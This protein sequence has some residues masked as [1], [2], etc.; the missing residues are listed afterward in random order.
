MEV[1]KRFWPLLFLSS[2]VSQP[3][4]PL[5]SDL[6]PTD[7]GL[8]SALLHCDI[9]NHPHGNKS[10]FLGN[11][12]TYYDSENINYGSNAWFG[13]GI[14]DK[15]ALPSW[16]S[17]EAFH[18]GNLGYPGYPGGD[19][20]AV[21]PGATPD[22]LRLAIIDIRKVDNVLHYHYFSNETAL[23][24]LENWGATIPLDMLAAAVTIRSK[25][26]GKFGLTGNISRTESIGQFLTRLSQTSESGSA[27][28]LKSLTGGRQLE[29][30]FQEWLTKNDP[31]QSFGSTFGKRM[32]NHGRTLSFQDEVL[33]FKDAGTFRRKTRSNTIKPIIMAEFWKRLAVNSQD[34][35]TW[36]QGVTASDTAILLYGNQ[37]PQ[38]DQLGGLMLHTKNMEGPILSHTI[39]RAALSKLSDDWRLFGKTGT[40]YSKERGRDEAAVG[41]FLCIPKNSQPGMEEGRLFAFFINAQTLGSSRK[42][43][44]RNAALSKIIGIMVPQIGN[45]PSVWNPV[46]SGSD[47]L[48][49]SPS[50]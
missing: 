20:R 19:R 39:P 12:I 49:R 41:G 46:P 11:E 29:S 32:K 5:T 43:Q 4:V 31:S 37:S 15:S 9:D 27:N 8:A 42:Y 16:I 2:C 14:R 21:S 23:N 38:L 1:L 10:L 13:Q 17:L 7:T 25:S 22:N 48:A 6:P 26:K 18:S 34:T 36:A 33:L 44:M 28:W 47:N 30:F 45:T 40:G 24:P 35:N 50:E 3:E